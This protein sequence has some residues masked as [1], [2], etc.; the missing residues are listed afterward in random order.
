MKKIIKFFRTASFAANMAALISAV[1]LTVKIT[2][3][4]NIPECFADGYEFGQIIERLLGAMISSYI[5]YLLVVHLREWRAKERLKPYIEK[6]ARSVYDSC[7][8]Q[9]SHFSNVTGQT[10]T[11]DT[12]THEEIADQFRQIAPNSHAPMVIDQA[13]TPA[14]WLKWFEYWI[15]RSKTSIDRVLSQHRFLDPELIA[16]LIAIDESGHYSFVLEMRGYHFNNPDM[17]AWADP[18][19]EYCAKCRELKAYLDRWV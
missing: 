12:V 18:F 16:L 13:G 6:Y 2:L 4:D 14:S 11:L 19:Y 7:E 9:L 1:I 5:F 3:L 10:L 17:S 15:N 8:S